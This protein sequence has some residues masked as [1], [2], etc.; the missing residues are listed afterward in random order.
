M[1][2]HYAKACHILFYV[3]DM[4]GKQR[5]HVIMLKFKTRCNVTVKKPLPNSC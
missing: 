5:Y 1:I 3:A 2:G 4:I